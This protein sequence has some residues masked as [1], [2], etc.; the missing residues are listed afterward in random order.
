MLKDMSY[1]ESGFTI[2]DW[3][4]HLEGLLGIAEL[5]TG[6]TL[7]GAHELPVED[8]AHDAAIAQDLVG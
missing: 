2:R 7:H 3:V 4:V 1:N 5:L 8:V 6:E